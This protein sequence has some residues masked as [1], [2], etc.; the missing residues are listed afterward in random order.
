MVLEVRRR[1]PNGKV[2]RKAL[3]DPAAP[4]A[5]REFR[6][7]SSELERQ[8]AAIWKRLLG[9]ERVGYHDNFFDLGAHSLLMVRAFQE[10]RGLVGDRI[11]LLELF[12]YPSIAAL[13][14]HLEPRTGARQRVEPAGLRAEARRAALDG[15]RE[16]IAVIGMKGR[17]PRAADVEEFWSNLCEGVEA[18]T[19]FSDTELLA[20]GIPPALL[21]DP[22]YVKADAVLEGADLFDAAFFGYSPREAR[23]MDPQQRLFLECAWGALEDAGYD[24]D[25]FAGA[26]G[27]FAG[28]SANRYWLNLFSNAELTAG[29]NAYLT[30][31]GN[32]K[33]FLPTRVSYKLN[34]KGPSLNVQTA[35]STSMVAVHL[36][37]QSLLGGECDMAL[38]GGVSVNAQ[39]G[40][41]YLYTE[42]GIASPDGHC[43]AFDVDARG[44]I[45]G[46]G[47]A[48]VVLKR[49]SA[50]VA[51]GDAIRAV[52][53]GS[54]VNNDGSDK[55]GYTAPS[56]SGQAAVIAEAQLVAGVEPDWIDYVEAHGTG[57]EVGDPIEIAAL[58]EA[59]R[60]R[61]NK[62]GYC[63]IGSVKTNIGHLDAAAGVTGLV[64]AV[65]A[66]EHAQIPPSLN[67]ERPNPRI[68]FARSPFYVNTRLAPWPASEGHRRLAAV[69]SF[70]LGGTN[71]HAI[72]EEAPEAAPSGA[73]RPFQLLVLSAKTPTGLE[74]ATDNLVKALE[75]HPDLPLADVAFTLQ[76][77][78]ARFACRRALVCR[79]L[80][81]ARR[82]LAA[83]DPERVLS[84]VRDAG[85]GRLVFMFP[86]SGTQ[87]PGMGLGLYQAEP[88]YRHAVDECLDLFAPLLEVPLWPLLYP[89]EPAGDGSDP[90][91]R[92][93]SAQAALFVTEYALAKLWISWGVQPGAMIG[94]SLGEYVAAHL[95]G[96]M[97]LP[98]AVALV[99]LRGRLL[100]G[101]PTGAML[102]VPLPESAILPGLGS[103]L[104][105]A[106]LNGPLLSV[107]SGPVAA[108][109]TAQE[110]FAA[111]GLEVR[112]LY[113]D[114]AFHSPM[115]EPVLPAFRDFV[116][117]LD[118]RPPQIPFVSSTT[119]VWIRDE[120]ATDPEYWVRHLRQTVRFG[121][122]LALL[123]AEPGTVLLEVGPGRTLSTLVRRHPARDA[124]HEVLSL[125]RSRGE[126][127]P[128][129][130]HT[131]D[132]L[133]RLWL[134][135]V[136][137]D[138]VGFHAAER[139]R[140]VALPSYPFE[141]RRFWLEARRPEASLAAAA[142]KRL[143]PAD[144]FYTPSWRP[145][146][147][148][149]PAAEGNPARWLVL[150]DGSELGTALAAGLR[151]RGHE[152]V[153]A[154]A[155]AR[156]ARLVPG[157]YSVDPSRPE[158][159]VSLLTDL[160][161][162]GGSLG[163]V[164]HLWSAGP[165]EP[166]ETPEAVLEAQ[167][168]G[169][170]SLVFLGQALEKNR[171]TEPVH[172]N[173]VSAGLQQVDP[174]EPSRP[175]AAP[176]LAA[177][178][179][180]P[181]EYP[182]IACRSIDLGLPRGSAAGGAERVLAEILAGAPDLAVAYRR[183]CRH[184]RS[185]DPLRL[186]RTGPAPVLRQGG[187]YWVTGGLGRVGRSVAG[188]LA[189]EVGAR[190][191]LSGRWP[192]PP[193]E[194]WQDWR[195]AHG[196]VDPASRR[197]R[198][199]IEL[200]EL[201]A[202][203]LACTA[204]VADEAQV[205]AVVEL[206]E[207]RFGRLDGVVHAAGVVGEKAHRSVGETGIEE[208]GW[209]FRP[210][211]LGTLALS[212]V[213]EE[214]DLDFCLLVSSLSTV[215]GGV[216]LGAYAAANLF[217]N[218]FAGRMSCQ[219]RFPWMSLVSDAWQ[220]ER[221]GE[222]EMGAG[223]SLAGLAMT[224]EE[225]AA[226]FGRALWMIGSPQV[227][228]STNSLDRRMAQ[229]LQAEPEPDQERPAEV[230]GADLRPD[231]PNPYVA[232]R[233]EME[234]GVA[235]IWRQLLGLDRVGVHDSFFALG[236]DS[237][238]ATRLASGLRRRFQT[239]IPL[240]VLFDKPT[241]AGQAT[242]VSVQAAAGGRG[243]PAVIERR[244]RNILEQLQ[245]L[246]DMADDPADRE[247]LNRESL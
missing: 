207:R 60:R 35:C 191:V 132:A 218:A 194:E 239:E 80:D 57:T 65:L 72:L 143:D 130:E 95:A 242:M 244:S 199:I 205:R 171:I 167:H 192:L 93:A 161:G 140:R 222:A 237:L 153:T 209:H 98:D 224:S 156:F 49:L 63:A 229:W 46:N 131:L 12:R 151:S 217:L 79:D 62:A 110:A 68:D 149:A 67:Y 2:D 208:V 206:A 177:C 52:I 47:L 22:S 202:E 101:L 27:V 181:Q 195:R 39:Q 154:A 14:E 89:G 223:A 210:K 238:L 190:L 123:L 96:V 18:V 230:G 158:D 174:A 225:G 163:H 73:S 203:V 233:D 97:S 122:G 142:G 144:W 160:C 88:V 232:P 8:I 166:A 234:T 76:T 139:R 7:P 133:A 118:L 176:L 86:G 113:L 148:P 219:G 215:L 120:E 188:Y 26:I 226:A 94:H 169:F 56:I 28:V 175:E 25:R 157:A 20:R 119:G 16:G 221:D 44:T 4:G 100:A 164:L 45:G 77:G 111:Q 32:D 85:P 247:L 29:E 125:L 102:S 59:F 10:L 129:L 152:V 137:V 106:A 246:E 51:D 55:V 187:V 58:I 40:I 128:D 6:P 173:V 146:P 42:G 170:L 112:R 216:G 185:L 87:Y 220:P 53:R 11:G 66:L 41:G 172:I 31:V 138:G 37:C 168:R 34:L 17:F 150:T 70:G 211:V 116:R 127:A 90:L 43:R 103:E 214:R 183:G 74:T 117:R 54:A 236:G 50:A 162:D 182:N 82:V 227:V 15:A 71:A 136:D 69:S 21:H 147:A 81:D 196:E 33:D 105:I 91:R 5:E 99:A 201:G 75:R 241:I 115:V 184:V 198:A 189:R 64:K 38:A 212:R 19:F 108:I 1:T 197:I 180:L 134:L 240:R 186:D 141:G 23:I 48:V 159:Y 243:A 92:T 36:A 245:D 121:E 200:E 78:R 126:A 9:V 145:S 124:G 135:G 84:Q 109:E 204:D 179:V 83:R 13:V 228:V 178:L 235:E 30:M 193:R 104:A 155:G 114:T 165:A 231:L 61:T 107:L 3:P 213:L 24:P